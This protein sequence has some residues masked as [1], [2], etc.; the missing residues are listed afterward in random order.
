MQIETY[1]LEWEQTKITII[2]KPNY[3]KAVEEI[4]DYQL[5]HIQV[6][7]DEALPITETGYRSIFLP[8]KEVSERA[9]VTCFI[10]ELLEEAA[11][12]P[13]WK[14][15]NQKRKQLSLF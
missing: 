12:S 2:Y 3:S 5:A 14:S 7:A 4:H 8:E 9:G 11:K 1:Q 15:F 13:K 6:K 10:W